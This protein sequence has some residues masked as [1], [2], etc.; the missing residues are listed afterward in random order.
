MIVVIFNFIDNEED[1][2]VVVATTRPETMLGDTGVAVN[3]KDDRYKHL[4]GKNVTFSFIDHKDNSYHE[5]TVSAFEFISLILRGIKA[6]LLFPRKKRQ[7][8][9]L[10]SLKREPMINLRYQTPILVSI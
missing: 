10:L 6:M 1:K 7:R 3:P 9:L 2:Y 4:I 8:D 5:K